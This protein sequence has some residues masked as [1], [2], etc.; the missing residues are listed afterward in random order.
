ME[1]AQ[2]VRELES[3]LS[4]DVRHRLSTLLKSIVKGRE[5]V[6]RTPFLKDSSVE[7]VVSEFE[8][9]VYQPGMEKLNSQLQAIESKQKEKIGPMSIQKPWAERKDD[10]LAGFHGSVVDPK[11]LDSQRTRLSGRELRPCTLETAKGSLK[12]TSSA[13]LPFL[14][15]KGEVLDGALDIKLG[16]YWPCVM[17]TR[18]QEQGKTRTVWGYPISMTL[19]EAQ[20]FVPYFAKF[21]QH[22]NCC[23]YLGP[24]AV[25]E[26]MT[27]VID[28]KAKD[29]VIYS[30]DYSGFDNSVSPSWA[31]AELRH[32]ASHFQ[33][34]SD[35]DTIIEYFN[36]C[37]IVTPD[38]ILA[39]PHGI[40]SGSM[41]TSIVGSSCHITAHTAVRG[42]LLPH[43]SQVMGDDGVSVHP[44]GIGKEYLADVYSKY[45][46]ELNADK[47]FES[48]AEV[49]YLQ[50]YYS[51]DYR[52]DGLIRGIYPVYRA[53]NRLMHMERWTEI[54]TSAISGADY[55]AIRAIAILEN[56][57]W[58]PLHDTMV[59]W[60][61]SRDKYG[62]EYS[63]TGLMEYV[64]N[65]QVRSKT[66]LKH[67]YSD[68]L[69]GIQ[70]FET[71]KVLRNKL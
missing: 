32:V 25:D 34:Q 51:S 15:P 4:V 42:T 28:R 40:P 26:A 60:V 23:A 53:L 8:A 5:D 66:G 35:F 6:V 69:Q 52:F 3:K 43:Q 49:I 29:E 24:D 54:D 36:T 64:N 41:F 70:A 47:T 65:Y 9:E 56:C 19:L 22:P 37:G 50:R 58:H 39:G 61:A 38:G 1:S 18:T 57:K 27:V 16:E 55:F 63:H 12:R 2:P 48:D 33:A 45:G 30:E 68:D 11:L 46:L 59:K 17:Y 67:Q 14:T 44:K 21:Q 7:E 20:Y 62:L 13:G 10:L 31:E 71:V